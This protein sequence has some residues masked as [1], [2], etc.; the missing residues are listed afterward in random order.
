ME[1]AEEHTI[2]TL[3]FCSISTGV[4]G[5]PI[6]EATKVAIEAVYSYFLKH[7]DSS[8]KKVVFNVFKDYDYQIYHKY[9]TSLRDAL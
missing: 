2:S 6:I 1:K 9:L 7:P 8:I 5:Y 3:A 4:Y